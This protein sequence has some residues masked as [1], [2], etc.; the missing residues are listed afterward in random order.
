MALGTSLFLIAV[1][2]ILRFAVTA[3][4]HGFDIQ[5]VGVI[6]MIVGGV[7]LVISLFWMMVWSGRRRTAVPGEYPAER[8]PA[9]GERY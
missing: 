4:A 3:T 5:T 1:G 9:P 7:G 6:L 2:A 8:Y